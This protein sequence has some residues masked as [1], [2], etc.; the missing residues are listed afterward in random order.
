MALDLR[1]SVDQADATLLIPA[2]SL[3][4]EAFA[5]TETSDWGACLAIQ[6]GILLEVIDVVRGSGCSFAVPFPSPSVAHPVVAETPAR[7]QAA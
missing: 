6:E 4:I 2:G 3:D 1:G 7:R 5:H